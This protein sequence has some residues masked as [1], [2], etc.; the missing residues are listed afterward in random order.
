MHIN[1]TPLDCL[2]EIFGYLELSDI[3]SISPTSKRFD[4]VG[5]I[6]IS[7]LEEVVWPEDKGFQKIL[8]SIMSSGKMV[9]LRRVTR[10][11]SEGLGILGSHYITS[12]PR[13][14][15]I[16]HCA[17]H[18]L[19]PKLSESTYAH[20][21]H[22]S[23]VELI[24]GS[25]ANFDPQLI[26]DCI[27]KLPCLETLYLYVSSNTL[28]QFQPQIVDKLS[29]TLVRL[30][31]TFC[32]VNSEPLSVETIRCLS[33][34]NLQIFRI[35]IADNFVDVRSIVSNLPVS[36]KLC[37]VDIDVRNMS[38]PVTQ[39]LGNV[40]NM[41]LPVL[42]NSYAIEILD[43]D[44]MHSS[45]F[46]ELA[47]PEK[48]T[49]HFSIF[50][51]KYRDSF[52][53]PFLRSFRQHPLANVRSLNFEEHEYRETNQPTIHQCFPN[54]ECL[55]HRGPNV[56]NH[57]ALINLKELTIHA[58]YAHRL[59]G[60]FSVRKLTLSNEQISD[61]RVSTTTLDSLL[62]NCQWPNLTDISFEIDNAKDSRTLKA[63][64]K[65]IGKH[66]NLKNVEIRN[67]NRPF[68]S[69]MSMSD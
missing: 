11:C 5:D 64:A 68:S 19:L 21:K 45:T 14:E 18:N 58:A 44:I 15:T 35:N 34:T 60:E 63:L 25:N 33:C 32:C 66:P 10:I 17:A 8:Q 39:S 22:A 28:N 31:Y 69:I 20:V 23:F 12:C 52:L 13:F 42:N 27:N 29:K 4:S 55:V 59:A 3:C 6:V 53:E 65:V 1:Q 48:L 57:S 24:F 26:L 41:L 47:V 67:L 51:L 50:C 38:R 9:K 40:F 36:L 43:S 7:N 62:Q 37:I 16:G 61:R 54:L 2:R 56:G 30:W 46:H 49:F